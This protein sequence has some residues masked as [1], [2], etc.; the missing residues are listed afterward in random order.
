[1]DMVKGITDKLIGDKSYISKKLSAELFKQKVTLI[2]KI[3][4]NMKNI[5]MDITDRMILMCRSFIKTIFSSMKSLNTMI[6]S[7]AQITY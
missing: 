2:T 5:L 6:H 3:K 7:N 4:K 1:M